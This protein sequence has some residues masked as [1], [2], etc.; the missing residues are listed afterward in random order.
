MKNNGKIPKNNENHNNSIEVF[1]IMTSTVFNNIKIFL[2]SHLLTLTLA[3]ISLTAI[4]DLK[5]TFTRS[6][7]RPFLS[8]FNNHTFPWYVKL[9]VYTSF[10]FLLKIK[11][12]DIEFKEDWSKNMFDLDCSENKIM[13]RYWDRY[14]RVQPNSTNSEH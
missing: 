14:N 4:R 3:T 12:E 10:I 11:K 8:A 5:M 1:R 7:K 13:K 2:N 9:D 6:W